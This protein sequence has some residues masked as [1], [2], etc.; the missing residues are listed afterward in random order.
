MMMKAKDELRPEYKRSDFA[1]LERGKCYAN[2]AKGTSVGLVELSVAKAF[3]TSKAVNEALSGL[4][5][6][7]E[8]TTLVTRPSTR[9]RLKAPSAGYTDASYSKSSR[10][11]S[12]K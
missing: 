6:L 2:V 10:G 8:K 12:N 5:A 3:P 4:V 11:E 9:T 7:A 1:R